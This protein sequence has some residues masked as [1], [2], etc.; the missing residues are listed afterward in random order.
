MILLLASNVTS[1][2]LSFPLL[3][4]DGLLWIRTVVFSPFKRRR[5]SFPSSRS[6]WPLSNSQHISSRSLSSLLYLLYLSFPLPA[7]L[8]P[9]YQKWFS[10]CPFSKPTI[11]RKQAHLLITD[12]G[13]GEG[14]Q[15][16]LKS[17]VLYCTYDFSTGSCYHTKN[18][19]NMFGCGL[20][21]LKYLT[22][23]F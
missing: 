6:P 23:G 14:D 22:L 18:T 21:P 19:G 13:E 10:R 2:I 7:L 3:W 9:W 15:Q 12:G 20:S 16:D 8:Y 17:D 4:G 5:R 11:P 1:T